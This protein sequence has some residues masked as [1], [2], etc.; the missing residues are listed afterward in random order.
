[1]WMSTW[2]W[3]GDLRARECCAKSCYVMLPVIGCDTFWQSFPIRVALSC[4]ALPLLCLSAALR[5]TFNFFVYM[6]MCMHMHGDRVDS[7]PLNP[8][9]SLL[10]V[11]SISITVGVPPGPTVFQLYFPIVNRT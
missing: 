7:G 9:F 2:H 5:F 11:L 4:P 8:L 10:T 1:M 3:L 6:C